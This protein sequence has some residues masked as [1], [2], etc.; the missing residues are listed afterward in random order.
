VMD[1]AEALVDADFVIL[2]VPD[3]LIAEV[4]AEVGPRM[5]EGT[6]M[7]LLDPAAA[8]AGVVDEPED[9]S[10]FVTHPCHPSLFGTA[11]EDDWFGG[12]GIAEQPIVCSLRQ[13][14]EEAYERGVGIAE[15]IFAPVSASHRV[16]TEQMAL[17]EPALVENVLTTFLLAVRDGVEELE[18]KGVPKK[19]T[20]DMVLGH[21]RAQLA[22]FFGD[23]DHDLSH[24]AGR[25]VEQGR[26][27]VLRS[28]WKG[29]FGSE[30]LR[31]NCAEI[32][33]VRE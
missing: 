12:Q 29:I 18:A 11:R 28:D 26:E 5:A 10:I 7:V 33:T 1:E 22:M 16:T 13:G 24:G 3:H 19:A 30:R 14:P 27:Q 31:E 2:A 15:T 25:A 32:A 17:L 6:M 21:L 23:L 4:S 20:T 8:Y 9:V